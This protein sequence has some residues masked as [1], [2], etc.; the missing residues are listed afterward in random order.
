MSA[1]KSI[2]LS[3]SRRFKFCTGVNLLLMRTQ[4][5][6]TTTSLA[7]KMLFRLDSTINYNTRQSI[8]Y[9]K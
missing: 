3:K 4:K 8:A 5:F 7:T 6:K 2:F 1:E 9:T